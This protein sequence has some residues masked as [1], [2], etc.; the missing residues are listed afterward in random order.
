[1]HI[2]IAPY[3]RDLRGVLTFYMWHILTVSQL[4]TVQTAGELVNATALVGGGFVIGGVCL[5]VCLSTDRVTQKVLSL[6]SRHL[7]G[8]W[9][10]A[11]GEN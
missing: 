3:C 5:F 9:T 8:L 7:V 2:C 1:M 6:F 11:S 4:R 10:A